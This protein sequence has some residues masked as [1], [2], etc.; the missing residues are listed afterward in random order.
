MH[1]VVLHRC[2][3]FPRRPGTTFPMHLHHTAVCARMSIPSFGLVSCE[4]MRSLGASTCAVR[5]CSSASTMRGVAGEQIRASWICLPWA[6]NQMER[7]SVV[8]CREGK[9]ETAGRVPSHIAPGGAF[10]S[11][12]NIARLLALFAVIVSLIAPVVARAD[13]VII[14]DPPPC[15]PACTEPFP[16]GDQLEVR[17]HRVDETIADQVA[18]T[19]SDQ[20]FRYR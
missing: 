13:G 16:V 15:N 19:R 9:R 2:L 1:R 14:V 11:R 10:M 12:R 8:G 7:S 20:V 4:R 18:T 3:G 17:S 6:G 5:E